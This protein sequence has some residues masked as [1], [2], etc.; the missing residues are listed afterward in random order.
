MTTSHYHILA[1]AHSSEELFHF[2]YRV[3]S[4]GVTMSPVDIT[5]QFPV[6]PN[7]QSSDYHHIERIVE[8]SNL[9]FAFTH[10]TSTAHTLSDARLVWEALRREGW[11]SRQ[12]GSVTTTT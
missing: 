3:F 2:R 1:R 6:S 5:Y 7:G 4:D 9:G 8:T 12:E 10:N 11:V